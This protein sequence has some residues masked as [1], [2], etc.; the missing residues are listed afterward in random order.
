LILELAPEATEPAP[1]CM[2]VLRV[3]D[4]IRCPSLHA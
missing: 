2:N 4:F 3:R 1:I